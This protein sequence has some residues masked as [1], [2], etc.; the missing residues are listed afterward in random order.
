MTKVDTQEFPGGPEVKDPA[1]S[2][3][4]HRFDPCPRNLHTPQAQPKNNIYTV[5]PSRCSKQ[6]HVR[7]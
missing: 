2:L 1:L 5:K 3:L 6:V 4:W 7:M